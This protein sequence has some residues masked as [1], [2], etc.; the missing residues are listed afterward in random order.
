MFQ[1]RRELR[2]RN[3]AD[4]NRKNESRI[5]GD[6]GFRFAIG[7][8]IRRDSVYEEPGAPLQELW[9]LEKTCMG[10]KLCPMTAMANYAYQS[11]FEIIAPAKPDLNSVIVVEAE[12]RGNPNFL[13]SVHG[14]TAAGPPSAATYERG[15]GN[16]FLFEHATSYARV[17]WQTGIA[18]SVPKQA[19]GIGEVILRDFGAAGS[20]DEQE[21][22]TILN[23][24]QA[25][26]IR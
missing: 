15:F 22:D 3:S 1:R 23:S 11:V 14:I 25:S 12:N 20:R 4:S 13:N 26:T 6:L 9:I 2:G 21:F 18:G 7:G 16:G 17:Q 24:I 10:S 19:E 8:N 5:T